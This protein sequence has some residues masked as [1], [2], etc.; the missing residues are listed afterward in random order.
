MIS[1]KEDVTINTANKREGQGRDFHFD[2]YMLAVGLAN[3][4]WSLF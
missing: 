2:M 3:I 4:F 1:T